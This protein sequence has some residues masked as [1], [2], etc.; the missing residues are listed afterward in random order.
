MKIGHA[1]IC[2]SPTNDEFYLI[3]YRSP[4]RLEPALGIHDDIYANSLLFDDG[5]KKV[6]FTGIES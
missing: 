1:R 3:G 4:T 6:C 2:L 5:F